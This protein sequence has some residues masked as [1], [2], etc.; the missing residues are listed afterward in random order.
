M[1]AQLVLDRGL[2]CNAKSVALRRVAPT[3][4][5]AL[6][7]PAGAPEEIRSLGVDVAPRLEQLDDHTEPTKVSMRQRMACLV[8]HLQGVGMFVRGTYTHTLH[9]LHIFSYRI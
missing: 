6:R 7:F 5:A 3:N 8:E 2:R 9:T 1:G 4:R